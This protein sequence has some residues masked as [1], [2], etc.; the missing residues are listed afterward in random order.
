MNPHADTR[1]PVSLVL[2]RN[3]QQSGQWQFPKWDVVVVLPYH[4]TPEAQA[5]NCR[6]V[7]TGE[8][9]EHF[10]WSGLWLEFFRDGLQGYYQNLSGKQPSLFVL[11]HEDDARTGMAPA[12]ISANHA[13]AEGHMESDGIV[14][15]TPLLAPFSTWVAEYILHHQ[16][17]LDRQ[18]ESQGRNKKGKRHRV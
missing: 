15:S 8:D 12:V 2:S 1:Y 10:L 17:E 6:H 3:W 13:D 5:V 7:H 14:L 16:T 4:T 18:I 11:C 9:G